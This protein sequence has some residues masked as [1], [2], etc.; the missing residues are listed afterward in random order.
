MKCDKCDRTYL[1]RHMGGNIE[2]WDE[3]A[4]PQMPLI[5]ANFKVD[6]VYHDKLPIKVQPYYND[7]SSYL[8]IYHNLN[9]KEP[10]IE[11]DGMEPEDVRFCRDLSWIKPT[12]ESAHKKGQTD[13][14]DADQLWHNEQKALIAKQAV[15]EFVKSERYCIGEFGFCSNQPGGKPECEDCGYWHFV[16]YDKEYRNQLIQSIEKNVY[17]TEA[18]K[19]KSELRTAYTDGIK[20]VIAHL[21]AAKEGM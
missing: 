18:Y 10:E 2:Y 1:H 12:L 8:L 5:K 4:E 7:E 20:A 21:R 3:P 11:S 17:K 14:R 6:V 19:G 15:S 13:Q 16:D 9:D